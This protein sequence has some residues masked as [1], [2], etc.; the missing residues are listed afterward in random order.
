MIN[1][2]LIEELKKPENIELIAGVCILLIGVIFF[3]NDIGILGN[4]VILSFMIIVIPR[5]ISSYL[6]YQRIR[7]MEEMFPVFLK[8][9]AEYLRSGMTLQEAIRNAAHIDYGKLSPEIKKIA[10]QL[11]W[12]IPLQEALRNFAERIRESALI[13]KSIEILVESYN[14]G[15]KIEETMDAIA[16][17]LS[18]VKE[19]DKERKSMMNHHVTTIYIIYFV[20]LGICVGLLKTVIPLAAMGANMTTGLFGMA[21]FQNPCKICEVQPEIG[22]ISCAV[23]NGAAKIFYLGGDEGAYYRGLFFVMLIIHGIFS[24]LLCGQ[25]GENSV[26]AGIRHS[27]TLTLIGGSLFLILV[28]M[29][30][31]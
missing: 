6:H 24:G 27:L 13:R 19:M 16:E 9:L 10:I 14:S 21:A 4:F 18:L 3:S 22:C 31:A 7:V 26:R 8:D 11:S 12:G 29:G 2:K 28:R 5:V 30:I 15:G 20:F 1:K 17:N 25:I 23:F